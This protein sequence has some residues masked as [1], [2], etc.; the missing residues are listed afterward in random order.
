[1]NDAPGYLNEDAPDYLNGDVRPKE[2]ILL[3]IPTHEWERASPACKAAVECLAR[4]ARLLLEKNRKYGDSAASPSRIFSKA[5]ASEQILV[6]IDDKLSRI[7]TSGYRPSKDEDTADDLIGYL[8]LLKGVE[9][10]QDGRG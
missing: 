4:I 8:A 2:E 6:R 9:A 1:M 7:R 10:T 5:N 3:A